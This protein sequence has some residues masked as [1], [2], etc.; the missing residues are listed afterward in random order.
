MRKSSIHRRDKAMN[1]DRVKGTI[2]EVVGSTKRKIG[3][4]AGNTSLQVEG[5]AQQMKGKLE[6]VLGRAKDAVE[7]ANQQAAGE[8]ETHNDL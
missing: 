3:D 7:E 2:N 8:H 5:V 1:N 6:N 4:L